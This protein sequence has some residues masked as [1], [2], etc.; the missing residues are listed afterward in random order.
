LI[1][2]EQDRK[3][4]VYYHTSSH[5]NGLDVMNFF[6]DLINHLG[7]YTEKFYEELA[8]KMNHE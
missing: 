3:E 2:K 1:R 5:R 4:S 8:D 7:G 6:F